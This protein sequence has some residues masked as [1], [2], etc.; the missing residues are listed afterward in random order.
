MMSLKSC[1][2]RMRVVDETTD[3]LIPGT[4][5]APFGCATSTVGIG[6]LWGLRAWFR[7]LEGVQGRWYNYACLY[8]GKIP[9]TGVHYSHTYLPTRQFSDIETDNHRSSRAID[10]AP[11]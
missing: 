10:L 7:W 3:R 11:S 6:N 9:G 8:T 1:M 5:Q 2:R 4:F